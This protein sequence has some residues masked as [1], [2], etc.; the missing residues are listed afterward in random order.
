VIP[1]SI[2][3]EIGGRPSV[4]LVAAALAIPFCVSGVT[5]A[6]HPMYPQQRLTREAGLAFR[7]HPPGD[8]LHCYLIA[9]NIGFV[10]DTR[11]RLAP[12]AASH[13]GF[14]D[15]LLASALSP[16]R[17]FGDASEVDAVVLYRVDAARLRARGDCGSAEQTSPHAAR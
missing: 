7:H 3:A 14:G 4:M 17:Q 5:A 16:I 10:A 13:S 1:A 8:K 12:S 2:L 15:G 6:I 11:G 9:A